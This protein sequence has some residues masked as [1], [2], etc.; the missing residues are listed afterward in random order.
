MKVL[1]DGTV[2]DDGTAP[3]EMWDDG[4]GWLG[5]WRQGGTIIT[6]PVT[7]DGMTVDEPITCDIHYARF[8]FLFAYKLFSWTPDTVIKLVGILFDD[9]Q[10]TEDND[11]QLII[12]TGVYH[13]HSV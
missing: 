10:V 13:D 8:L 1:V 6:C 3:E 5:F 2:V 7:Q 11:G 4:A 12:N 9:G